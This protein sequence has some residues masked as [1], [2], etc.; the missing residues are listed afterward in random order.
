MA[1]LF[2]ELCKKIAPMLLCRLL[3][4]CTMSAQNRT[5]AYFLKIS[6]VIFHNWLQI[7]RYR[8]GRMC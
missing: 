6:T 7:K 5:E 8:Y 4:N 2:L 3:G 1:N